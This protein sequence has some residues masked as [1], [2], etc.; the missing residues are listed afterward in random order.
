[1]PVL[2]LESQETGALV[3]RQQAYPRAWLA[4]AK[5]ETRLWQIHSVNRTDQPPR[6][7][8]LLAARETGSPNQDLMRV[9]IIQD[10]LTEKEVANQ[11]SVSLASLSRWR[12]EHRGPPFV[13]VGALVRCRPEDLEQWLQTLPAGGTTPQRHA[14]PLTLA[15]G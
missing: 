3:R 10:F 8:Q 6:R 13:K 7:T 12:L 5:E 4:S 11:I 15:S 14:I 2:A 1:M 9:N